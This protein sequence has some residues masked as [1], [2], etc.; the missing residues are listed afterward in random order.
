MA[1][2]VVEEAIIHQ[3]KRIINDKDA[4]LD[5]ILVED[6]DFKIKSDII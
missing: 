2:N 3:S 6:I 5:L 1:R 4:E